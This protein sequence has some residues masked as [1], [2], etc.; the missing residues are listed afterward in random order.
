MNNECR[1]GKG[2]RKMYPGGAIRNCELVHLNM[3][4]FAVSFGEDVERCEK[5]KGRTDQGLGR[6]RVREL[7]APFGESGHPMIQ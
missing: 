2:M 7:G 1:G 3:V 5:L 6:L 4:V